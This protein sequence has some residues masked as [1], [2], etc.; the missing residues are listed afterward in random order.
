MKKVD[1]SSERIEKAVEWYNA[2][3]LIHE[4]HILNGQ[5]LER[6]HTRIKILEENIRKHR[7]SWL[8]GDDKCWKDNVELYKLL[9]EGFE[10]PERDESVELEDCKKYLHSCHHPGVAYVSPQRRIEM[11]ECMVKKYEKILGFTS[12][13][14]AVREH[15]G[16]ERPPTA[17]E[18]IREAGF[19]IK[20]EHGKLKCSCNECGVDDGY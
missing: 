18:K 10:L 15:C 17:E 2:K 11:L 6:A 20:C 7:D 8:N 12:V 16:M 4:I 19:Y 13:I 14:K 5:R 9:P 1:S 3:T